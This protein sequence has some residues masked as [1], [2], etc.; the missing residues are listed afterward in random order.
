MRPVDPR[1]L[2]KIEPPPKFS[3]TDRSMPFRRWW[4]QVE[5]FLDGQPTEVIGSEKRRILWVSRQLE[6]EALEWYQDWM[7]RVERGL[8]EHQWASFVDELR[9]RFTDENEADTAYRELEAY[10]YRE[11]IHTFLI[12]WDVLC[13]RAEVS[14]MAYRKMLHAAVGPALRKRLEL[15]ERVNTDK[16]FRANVLKAGRNLEDWARENRQQSVRPRDGPEPVRDARPPPRSTPRPPAIPQRSQTMAFRPRPVELRNAN[17]NPNPGL[18]RIRERRFA[19]VEEAIRGV[20]EGMVEARKRKGVCLRCGW[21][22]H[23][24]THCLRQV[25]T[26]I[27]SGGREERRIAGL[28]RGQKE[29]E[30]GDGEEYEVEVERQPKRSRF[31]VA[32]LDAQEMPLYDDYGSEDNFSE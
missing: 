10:T 25:E 4:R 31:E 13:R 27:V 3:G 23:L 24:A 20:P 26:R 8:A 2:L 28:K 17:P 1:A 7:D 18:P 15:Y 30:Y 5:E 6:R 21:I 14:G 9:T 32:A 16:E 12:R 19:S 11:D 22:G 29:E